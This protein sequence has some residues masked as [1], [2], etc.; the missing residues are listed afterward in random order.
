MGG[1]TRVSLPIASLLIFSLFFL[2]IRM[3]P[4][5]HAQD[6]AAENDDDVRTHA[7]YMR[8]FYVRVMVDVCASICMLY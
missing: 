6:K 2:F 8:L 4:P 7:I 3:S 5:E 1:G